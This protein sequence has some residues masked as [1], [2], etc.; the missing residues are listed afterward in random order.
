MVYGSALPTLT[1]INRFT[2]YFQMVLPADPWQIRL[3][4]A[5]QPA[6][7]EWTSCHAEQIGE[8]NLQKRSAPSHG[9]IM[10]WGSGA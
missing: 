3:R 2:D 8:V 5:L 6:P 9:D 7:R 4:G 1:M 10:I